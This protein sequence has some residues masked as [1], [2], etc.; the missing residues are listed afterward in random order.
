LGILI[1]PLCIGRDLGVTY[2]LDRGRR[3]VAAESVGL[4]GN[5]IKQVA[6][7]VEIGAIGGSIVGAIGGVYHYHLL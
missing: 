3:Y 7:L 5:T 6:V 1:S 2:A 4:I